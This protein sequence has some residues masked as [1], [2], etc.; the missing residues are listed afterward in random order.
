[1]CT[2]VV[3]VDPLSPFPVLLAGV[4]DEFA[5]RPWQPPAAHWPDR[6]AL[7]GGRDLQAGGTWLAVRDGGSGPPRA[8]CVLNGHGRPAPEHGRASRGELPLLAAE[9]GGL[10]GLDP[11]RFDPFHL[12]CAEPGGVRLWSWDG[13][14]FA[15]R[16]LGPGLH[17][18]VNTGLE[19]VTQE[20]GRTPE[21]REG[22][23]QMAARIAHFRPLLAAARRPEPRTGGA[24]EAW[25]AW[26][27]LLDGG[28][29]D[30]A[31]RRALVLTRDFEGG[32]V[33]GT[34]SVSLIG[35]AERGARYDFTAAPGDPGAWTTVLPGPEA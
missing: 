24:A 22:G 14:G 18:I 17:M 28:G 32:R 7:V 8:A 1:M 11:A 6:P 4:R 23:A 27:P 31:D 30:R 16:E 20:P 35:L 26:L 33:W 9:T 29:L 2:A 12:V 5:E 19:G 3:S 10:D 25:G 34:S 21:E 15:E 13:A